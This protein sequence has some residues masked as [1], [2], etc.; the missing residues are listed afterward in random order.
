MNIPQALPSAFVLPLLFGRYTSSI[1]LSLIIIKLISNKP[2]SIESNIT[3]SICI[4]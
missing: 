1:P 2:Q 3:K 4:F